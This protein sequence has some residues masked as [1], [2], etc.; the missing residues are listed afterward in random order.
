[1]NFYGGTFFAGGFFGV[2]APQV[3]FDDGG[4]KHRKKQRERE[5]QRLEAFK[6]ANEKRR[7]V[8]LQATQHAIQAINGAGEA[9]KVQ[10]AIQTDVRGFDDDEVLFLIY[11]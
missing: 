5:Q 7:A 10:R 1:V 6:Q 4:P 8:L 11:G 2:N 9:L 3:G